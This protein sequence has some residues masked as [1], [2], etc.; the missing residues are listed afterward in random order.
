MYNSQILWGFKGKPKRFYG[1]MRRLQTV[2]DGVSALKRPS[3]EFT[4]TDQQV[5]DVLGNFFQAVFTKEE[6]FQDQSKDDNDD[7][8]ALIAANLNS[9]FTTD[10]VINKLQ[11]LQPDKSAGPD[12]LHPILLR[13]CAA[14]VAEPLSIIIR[15]SFE[16]GDVP[17]DWKTANIVPIYKKGP[18]TDP[19]NYRPVLLTY[20]PARLWSHSSRKHC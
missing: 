11:C 16:T 6:G 17:V 7:D 15:K 5:A 9:D 19:A 13:N 3:G 8:T 18:K 12:N 20:V 10:A 4:T 1:H 14:A 2:K